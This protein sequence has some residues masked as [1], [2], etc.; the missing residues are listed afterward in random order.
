MRHFSTV[1]LAAALAACAPMTTQ[2]VDTGDKTVGERL[3]LRPDSA[4]NEL[5]GDRPA[6]VW[7]MEG[8]P[9]DRLLIY[10]GIKDGDAIHPPARD[11]N[12]KSFRFRSGMQADEIVSMFEG[13]LTRDGSAFS[14]VKLEPTTFGGSKG[15]RFEYKLLRK[16]DNVPLAGVGYAAINDGQL[17]TLLYSAPRLTFF[18]RHQASVE[19]LAQSARILAA[20]PAAVAAAAARLDPSP[21]KTDLGRG[22]PCATALECQGRGVTKP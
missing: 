4:W 2:K 15:V 6:H 12:A 5:P 14:L 17:F 1:V 10:S 7:T 8:V 13:M 16:A 21:Q 22:P 3:V 9:I 18:P 20:S 11:A 19:H